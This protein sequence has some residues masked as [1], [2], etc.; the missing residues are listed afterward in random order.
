MIFR[1]NG[2]H[3][4]SRGANIIPMTQFD[5]ESDRD[6][7]LALVKSAADSNMNMLR[8]WGGGIIFP[9]AFYD[10]CDEHGIMIYHDLLFVEEQFHSASGSKE[11]EDEIRFIIRQ[12][13]VLFSGMDAMRSVWTLKLPTE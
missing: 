1:I 13:R 11:E 2:S 9:E 7:F 4:F 10:A 8:V 3:L 6:G 5:G 12:L